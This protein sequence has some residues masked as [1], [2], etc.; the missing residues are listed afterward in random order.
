MAAVIC[1]GRAHF[2]SLVGC[3]F[4]CI[5]MPLATTKEL[6]FLL[7]NNDNLQFA[8]DIYPGKISIH[9][10][11]INY[12]K[13]NFIWFPNSFKNTNPPSYKKR[14]SM[15]TR[16]ILLLIGFIITT[17]TVVRTIEHPERDAAVQKM[18]RYAIA[19]H[20][21]SNFHLFPSQIVK[22]QTLKDHS[23]MRGSY[24]VT[25][26]RMLLTLLMLLNIKAWKMGQPPENV[27]VTLAKT[28]RQDHLCLSMG[29]VS[30]P[31][32]SCLV[33]IPFKINEPSPL[34]PFA[35]NWPALP[36][37]EKGP[38][39]EAWEQWVKLIPKATTDA[40]KENPVANSESQEL[41]LLVSAKAS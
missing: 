8:L 38:A 10:L 39:R 14:Q 31:L 5:Y 18:L 12:L 23:E 26:M 19:Q 33:G 22:K 27:W 1:K 21:K 9:I 16:H 28:L 17:Q 29:S 34:H 11:A 15:E 37:A 6:D 13:Q 2:R 20:D 41:D 25:V 7:Q 24:R 4:A 32:S 36:T 40:H 35:G 30:S 3:D